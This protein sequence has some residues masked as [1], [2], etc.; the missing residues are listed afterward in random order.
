MDQRDRNWLLSK[1]IPLSEVFDASGMK[2]SEYGAAMR[3]A[4]KYVA[5]NV[6]PCKKAGHRIR[7]RTGKCMVCDI[8]QY[9]YSRRY[10]TAGF[11]YL[12]ASKQSGLIKVGMSIN[13]ENRLNTIRHRKYGGVSDWALVASIEVDA[14]GKHEAAVQAQLQ[15]YQATGYY[16]DGDHKQSCHELFECELSTAVKAFR[17]VGKSD[18]ITFHVD[19][20]GFQS[21]DAGVVHHLGHGQSLARPDRKKPTDAMFPSE[22]ASVLK[23]LAARRDQV[24]LHAQLQGASRPA[25]VAT[26]KGK[27]EKAPEPVQV[28]TSVNKTEEQPI[29]LGLGQRKA[30]AQA[31]TFHAAK[32]ENEEPTKVVAQRANERG[33]SL[34]AR[35]R[36]WSRVSGL[37]LSVGVFTLVFALLFVGV[38]GMASSLVWNELVK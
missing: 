5:I 35:A 2:R 38:V 8:K 36:Y 12:A 32:P 37:I 26:N 19:L 29:I 18:A 31:L 7:T 23:P 16:F 6:T 20:E 34:L 10:S 30:S 22:G 3:L 1:E 28:K 33:Y 4:G 13:L 21:S 11:V 27:T 25:A 14:A 15:A 9:A 24:T 17:K